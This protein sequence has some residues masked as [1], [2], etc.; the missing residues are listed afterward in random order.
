MGQHR[1][2]GA[3]AGHDELLNTLQAGF[4]YIENESF[5]STFD[6]PVLRD[7]SGSEKLGKSYTERNTKL[8]S[9]IKKIAKGL[10]GV[11]DR[12]RHAWAM[13]TNT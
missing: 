4:K 10:V 5:A 3:H 13:P 11:L 2:H 6:G 7:Q 8:C 1:R 12:Q 9:I